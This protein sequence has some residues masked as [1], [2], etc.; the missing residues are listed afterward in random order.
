MGTGSVY[1]FPKEWKA[2]QNLRQGISADR[3]SK[4]SS[5]WRR[6]GDFQDNEPKQR[7]KQTEA[8]LLRLWELEK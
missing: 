4:M 8:Y 2:N 5:M 7:R 1:D 6:H 3:Y